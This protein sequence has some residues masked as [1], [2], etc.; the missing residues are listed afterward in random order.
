M[1]IVRR[2][3]MDYVKL[4]NLH[5][6][7]RQAKRPNAIIGKPQVNYTMPKDGTQ[8]FG[9]LG[10]RTIIEEIEKEFSGWGKPITSVIPS[11]VL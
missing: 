1:P 5:Y 2:E 10:D 6:I 8:H 11:T 3:V 7:R 4:W 9:R